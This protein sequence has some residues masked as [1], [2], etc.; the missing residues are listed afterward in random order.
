MI[1][2]IAVDFVDSLKGADYWLPFLFL[3]VF[4]VGKTLYTLITK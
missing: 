1:Q 2:K 3:L 4:I